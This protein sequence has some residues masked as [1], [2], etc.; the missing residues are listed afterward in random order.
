MAK[1]VTHAVRFTDPIQQSI[2]PDRLLF[3][4]ACDDGSVYEFQKIEDAPLWNMRARGSVD[5]P[6]RTWTSRKAPLPT[7]V[8]ETLNEAVGEKRWTK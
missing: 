7:D 2:G 3:V 4:L 1:E 5:E 8:K 6:P